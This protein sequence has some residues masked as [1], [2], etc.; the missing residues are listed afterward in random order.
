[1][2]FHI[3]PHLERARRLIEERGDDPA[4][5]VYAALELRLG[6]ERVCYEKLRLRLG[7]VS[8]AEW[9]YRWQAPIVLKALEE[10][11][12][13]HI[14]EDLTLH[15]AKEDASVPPKTW[16]KIGDQKG[17]D[18]KQLKEWW[19]KLGS[20]LHVRVPKAREQAISSYPD[21]DWLRQEL[22]E[23]IGALEPISLGSGDFFFASPVTTFPCSCGL[24]V[25]RVNATL[26][27]GRV[28]GCIN[29]E[30]DKEW[31][32]RIKENGEIR[33]EENKI[34]IPICKHCQHKRYVEEK[35]IRDLRFGQYIEF[36]C[37]CG[38]KHRLQWGIASVDEK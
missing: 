28:I 27:D 1:M 20:F 18:P 30:C 34:E 4:S 22:F 15:V 23:M 37:D 9:L 2:S 7:H 14:A 33:F 17:V 35:I 5:L 11:A 36:V 32:V 16:L 6:L 29:P 8:A 10:L 13:P 24:T 26:S 38:R 3:R 21:A 31:R 19:N 12:D 25:T